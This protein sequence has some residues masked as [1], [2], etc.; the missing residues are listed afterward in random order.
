[1]DQPPSLHV[2]E[3]KTQTSAANLLEPLQ[4]TT[5]LLSD[6]RAPTEASRIQQTAALRRLTYER[7]RLTEYGI[8]QISD[9]LEEQRLLAPDEID[10]LK[11]LMRKRSQHGIDGDRVMVADDDVA[12]FRQLLARADRS[13]RLNDHSNAWF[14]HELVLSAINDGLGGAIQALRPGVT[15]REAHDLVG[16]AIHHFKD[17]K[18]ASIRPQM[19]KI[20]LSKSEAFDRDDLELLFRMADRALNEGLIK[21]GSDACSSL[22]MRSGPRLEPSSFSSAAENTIKRLQDWAGDRNEVVRVAPEISSHFLSAMTAAELNEYIAKRRN[23]VEPLRTV[24]N[25]PSPKV[26]RAITHALEVL[27]LP[28]A[29]VDTLPNSSPTALPYWRLYYRV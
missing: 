4:P 13:L 19:L 5:Q 21:H 27:G 28:G 11:L 25:D 14:A 24:E 12:V 2:S 6:L 23:N 15:I 16:L 20:W 1:M 26:D 18:I 17:E 3:A 8:Q 7:G 10:D 9:I 29:V 22:S